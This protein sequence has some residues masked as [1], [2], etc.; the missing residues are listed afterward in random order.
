MAQESS[1]RLEL[2][3]AVL[4]FIK[5]GMLVGTILLIRRVFSHLFLEDVSGIIARWALGAAVVG[6]CIAI[7]WA[8]GFEGS[9]SQVPADI[10]GYA[11]TALGTALLTVTGVGFLRKDPPSPSLSTVNPWL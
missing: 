10:L 4:F 7:G 1:R 3:G 6:A 2:L 5:F 8:A 9:R 11:V